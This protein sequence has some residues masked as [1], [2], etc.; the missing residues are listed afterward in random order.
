MKTEMRGGGDEAERC[1]RAPPHLVEK[2]LH[3]PGATQGSVC[4]R[5]ASRKGGLPEP[6]GGQHELVWGLGC[7]GTV[8][9]AQKVPVLFCVQE[10]SSTRTARSRR[11]SSG[12]R[13]TAEAVER[14]GCPHVLPQHLS[15]TPHT[16]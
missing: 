13:T 8:G 1:C 12:R 14:E 4:W 3:V 16:G 2:V 10:R 7:A 6:P 5:P 15:H 11:V 9:R